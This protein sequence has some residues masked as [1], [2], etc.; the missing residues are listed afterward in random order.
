MVMAAHSVGQR[1]VNVLRAFA[2]QVRRLVRR[3]ADDHPA[4]GGVS[5]SGR[6]RTQVRQGRAISAQTTFPGRLRVTPHRT[7]S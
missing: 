2:N 7:A 1:D 4:V 3:R 6:R 5:V